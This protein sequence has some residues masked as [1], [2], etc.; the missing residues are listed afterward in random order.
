[1]PEMRTDRFDAYVRLAANGANTWPRI[2]ATVALLVLVAVIGTLG[3]LA[4][5]AF[6][7]PDDWRTP[8]GFDAAL[9]SPLGLAVSL[10]AIALLWLGLLAGVRLLH[11]RP[12]ASVIGRDGWSGRRDLAAGLVAGL[13]VALVA[14]VLTIPIGP[15]PVRSDIALGTWVVLCLPLAALVLLQA[16][17]E[18]AVFRGYLPQVLAARGFGPLVWFL[19]PTLLFAAM[20]WYGD[21]PLW[22]SLS[23]VV[24]IAAFAAGMMVVVVRTGSIAAAC[25]VHW[26]NNL[27]AL[28]F[29]ALDDELGPAALYHLPP[30]ADPAWNPAT[31]GLAVLAAAAAAAFQVLLLLH[32]RSPLRVVGR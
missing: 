16:S 1:M 26:G 4:A 11:R 24:M 18:E 6:L 2:S 23:I 9:A 27:V 28:Q 32:P 17:A 29:I 12:L 20:H 25:G 22:K 8:E 30:L 31:L 19:V 3:L 13:A 5:L 10:A 15:T 7:G 21:V 14:S